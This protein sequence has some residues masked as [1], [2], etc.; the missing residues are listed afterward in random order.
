MK[1]NDLV[2]WYSTLTQESVSRVKELYHEEAHFRDPFNNVYGHNAIAAI[3]LHMFENTQ[4][5]EFQ[6]KSVNQ[7]GDSAWV[8]WV[9]SCLLRDK[10]LSIEGVSRLEFCSDGRV[11]EHRDYWD[12]MD[13][14]IELPLLGR[15]VE[16][17][18]SRMGPSRM[19]FQRESK[20]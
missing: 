14:F 1:L 9:F 16:Y 8:V 6:I 12:S 4:H 13:M 7:A 20:S 19:E 2:D 10:A 11:I 5:P 17:L 3:F 15:I 18:K